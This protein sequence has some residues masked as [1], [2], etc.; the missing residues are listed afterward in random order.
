MSKK[1]T[2]A[3]PRQKARDD[4][5]AML[6]GIPED[7]LRSF[8]NLIERAAFLTVHCQELE[9]IISATGVSEAYQN[10]ENQSGY[11]ATPAATAYQKEVALLNSVMKNLLSIAPKET[12]ESNPLA[13]FENL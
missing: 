2:T 1:L 13:K 6:S 11:K 8:D 10:G 4:I 3:T 7:R 9:D 12:V 5:M